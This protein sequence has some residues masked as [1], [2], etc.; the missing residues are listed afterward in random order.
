[1]AL[2]MKSELLTYMKDGKGYWDYEL[3]D[4]LMNETGKNTDYWKFQFRFWL[5][6]FLGCGLIKDVEYSED[7]GSKFTQG[8]ILMKYEITDLGL[9][10]IRTMLE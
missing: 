4:R 7:D 3:V 9:E 8:N 5:M 2:P 6:E 10:R 1:M